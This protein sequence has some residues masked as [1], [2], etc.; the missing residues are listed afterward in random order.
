MRRTTPVK[1]EC[2]SVIF[3]T[4]LGVLRDKTGAT[5]VDYGIVVLLLSITAATAFDT[6]GDYLDSLF[7]MN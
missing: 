7:S 1:K 4:I 5:A 2:I 3:R 6:F